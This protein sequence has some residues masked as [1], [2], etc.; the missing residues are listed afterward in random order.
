MTRP[1]GAARAEGAGSV[2]AGPALVVTEPARTVRTA[3]VLAAGKGSRLGGA[4]PKPLHRLLGLPLLLRTLFTLERA[5]ITDVYVVLGYRAD[6]VRRR[7]ESMRKPDLRIHWLHNEQWD[8]PNGLSVLAAAGAI[9]GRFLLAMGDHVFTP[10]AVARLT[11]GDPTGDAVTLL[12]DRDLDRI[13]DLEEATKVRL[14]GDRIVEIGKSIAEYD[15]VD[16]GLFLAT[17]ALFDAVRACVERGR[18][19][20]SAGVGRLADQGR[21]AAVDAEGAPWDDV[22]TPADARRAAR[23]L[24]AGLRKE[25]DGP[26][27]RVLNRR[28]STRITRLLAKT[29]ITPNQVSVAT[30]GVGLVAA[31]LAAVGGYGPWLACGLL[32][33]LT[34][35]L[36]G[37]DG[38]LATLTFRASRRGEWIDT[39]CDNITYVATLAGLTVGAYRTGLDDLYVWSGVAGVVSAV[40]ALSSIHLYLLAEGKSGSARS[41]RYAY[42]ETPSPGPAAR[43]L[44][45]LYYA[46]KRDVFS[47]IALLL[48]LVGQLP[49]ALPIVGIGGPLLLVPTTVQAA[50]R[51]MRRSGGRRPAELGGQVRSPARGE[52]EIPCHEHG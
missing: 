22:D 15:A 24:L 12:V 50:R 41:V 11:E 26:V 32:F 39:V 25:K 3:L 6:E 52:R 49:L 44:R 34:S 51:A 20:L 36:D 40:L 21:A 30:L 18:E 9:R 33:Q 14:D 16:T 4:E 10:S 2:V 35:I 38:E 42:Q 45:V 13:A 31:A 28:I 7:I 5:G 46:G 43:L 27:A 29:P 1:E 47:M 37:V 17:P 8:R 23:N 48:A 19:T